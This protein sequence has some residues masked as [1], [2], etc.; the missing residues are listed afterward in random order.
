MVSS[1][2]ESPIVIFLCTR[3]WY[4]SLTNNERSRNHD[5]RYFTAYHRLGYYFHMMI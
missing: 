3:N 4:S 1:V 2:Y 5:H